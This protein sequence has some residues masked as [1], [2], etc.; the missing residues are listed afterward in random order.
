M[1][2]RENEALALAASDTGRKWANGNPDGSLGLAEGDPFLAGYQIMLTDMKTIYIVTVFNGVVYPTTFGTPKDLKDDNYAISFPYSPDQDY[3]VKVEGPNQTAAFEAAKAE[4][5]KRNPDA[6]QGGI[7]VIM[8]SFAGDKNGNYAMVGIF[9][10]HD[11]GDF[12]MGG[13]TFRE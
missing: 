9:A 8:F 12:S 10:N 5:T 13:K 7:S 3:S 11:I 2:A 1:T 4:V 6:T